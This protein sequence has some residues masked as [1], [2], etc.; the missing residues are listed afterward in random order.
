MRWTQTL[1]LRLRR[2][3]RRFA[4]QKSSAFLSNFPCP[5]RSSSHTQ[6]LFS[7][8]HRKFLMKKRGMAYILLGGLVQAHLRTHVL[9]V[10]PT[11]IW[12]V[13]H[14]SASTFQESTPA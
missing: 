6:V 9:Q 14:F 11:R 1:L 8:L 12:N 13:L 3:Y 5:A 10:L 4:I 2:T 7:H